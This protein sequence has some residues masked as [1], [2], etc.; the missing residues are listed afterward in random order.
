MS[1]WCSADLGLGVEHETLVQSI[2]HLHHQLFADPILQQLLGV[3]LQHRKLIIW[4]YDQWYWCCSIYS[5][6]KSSSEH[7]DKITG[8]F[9]Y[10]TLLDSAGPPQK[11]QHNLWAIF[12]SLEGGCLIQKRRLLVLVAH[13]INIT[14]AGPATAQENQ[15]LNIWCTSEH[16]IHIWTSDPHLNIW[17]HCDCSPFVSSFTVAAVSTSSTFWLTS[18]FVLPEK[19]SVT[20]WP[21]KRYPQL[22]NY[23]L[24]GF[25]CCFH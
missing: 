2:G 21:W 18:C 13:L 20:D 25:L 14:G 10:T 16:L 7:L 6:G 4:T 24:F 19:T 3:N 12:C 15:H 22:I 5:I 9:S 8:S 23:F 1:L 17:S 11:V